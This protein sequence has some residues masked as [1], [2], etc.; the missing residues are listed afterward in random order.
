[1]LGLLQ[2]LAQQTFG[3]VIPLQAQVGV[4]TVITIFNTLPGAVAP[5][6]GALQ[7]MA[8]QT[9]TIIGNLAM[10]V[11]T[12][13]NAAYAKAEG[14]SN[15]YLNS[16]RST[17]QTTFQQIGTSATAVTTGV[18]NAYR[19]AESDAAGYLNTMRSTAANTFSAISQSAQQVATGIN[20]A[21]RTGTDDAIGYL[22]S[23]R[24]TAV[25]DFAAI[26]NAA[27]TAAQNVAN[28]GGA[29]NASTSAVNG[30]VSA[31]NSIPNI[32][33]TITITTNEVHHVYTVFGSSPNNPNSP[34]PNRAQFGVNMLVDKPTHILAGEGWGKE[35]VKVSPGTMGFVEDLGKEL[36]DIFSNKSSGSTSSGFGGLGGM[37]ARIS[38][39]V[40]KF[41]DDLFHKIG[42]P[43]YGT[44][45]G[46]GGGGGSGTGGGGGGGTPQPPA[47]FLLN[48]SMKNFGVYPIGHP[49]AGEPILTE[50]PGQVNQGK[51]EQPYPNIGTGT[52]TGGSG[53]GSGTGTGGTGG[54][55]TGTGG[56]GN[57]NTGVSQIIS[58]IDSISQ[59]SNQPGQNNTYSHENINTGSNVMG[60][61][62]MPSGG[63]VLS[64]TTAS[65]INQ[66]NVNMT[67]TSGTGSVVQTNTNSIKTQTVHE[68]PVPITLEIDGAILT[69]KIIKL[70]TQELSNAGVYG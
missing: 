69:R 15:G 66:S 39:R 18:N 26:T 63:G 31:M 14:D 43:F 1:M 5:V 25:A 20:N 51:F 34:T 19:S 64:N 33:R 30:L 35:R 13:V 42:W 10:L 4:M 54:S 46:S 3:V 57:S 61:V 52:N 17:A 56:T 58:Q 68:T 8:Q 27:R 32:S 40:N 59:H 47:R 21:F 16:M 55:G 36:R 65:V 9:F 29:A 45:P 49:H 24:N 44:F 11:A 53:S 28:I 6:M 41:I 48:P 60:V 50:H 37:G 22:N 70:I 62:P 12:G 23:L 67:G 7:S 2:S 38:E